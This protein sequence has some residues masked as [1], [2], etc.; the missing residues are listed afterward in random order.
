MKK[1]YELTLSQQ[2]DAIE[3]AISEVNFCIDA[4]LIVCDSLITDSKV[5]DWAMAAAEDAWYSESK[6]QIISED[7]LGRYHA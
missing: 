6:D 1:F 3:H 2:K 5:R 4:D 7:K